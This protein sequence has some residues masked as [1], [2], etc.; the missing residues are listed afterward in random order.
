MNERN[1]YTPNKYQR[2]SLRKIINRI[3][4]SGN[5]NRNLY[6]YSGRTLTRAI[7]KTMLQTICY[8]DLDYFN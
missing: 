8:S 3:R 6:G 2:A 4:Y 1:D 7:E 5:T